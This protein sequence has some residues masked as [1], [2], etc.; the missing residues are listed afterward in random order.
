MSDI[1]D[2]HILYP[3]IRMYNIRHGDRSSGRKGTAGSSKTERVTR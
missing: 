1:I 3:T 2:V